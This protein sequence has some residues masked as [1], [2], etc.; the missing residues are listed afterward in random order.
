MR[1]RDA[2][3]RG[4]VGAVPQHHLLAAQDAVELGDQS[5]GGVESLDQFV[6]SALRGKADA[7]PAAERLTAKNEQRGPRAE[8]EA[9]LEQ[10]V[11]DVD[12]G[13]RALD[14]LHGVLDA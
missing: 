14:R 6:V 2:E 13:A 8:G 9:L 10:G 4:K 7:F 11:E 5:R 12:L 3:T 1:R